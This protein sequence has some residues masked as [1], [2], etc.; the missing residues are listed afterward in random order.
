MQQDEYAGTFDGSWR[1]FATALRNEHLPILKKMVEHVID[2]IEQNLEFL[3]ESDYTVECLMAGKE[4]MIPY[5]EQQLRHVRTFAQALAPAVQAAWPD[6]EDYA[7]ER[8]KERMYEMF[9]Y[10]C[11]IMHLESTFNNAMVPA[12]Y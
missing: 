12:D 9:I 7:M 10:D 6:R 4:K 8:D 11:I 1:E 2:G 5:L 3:E